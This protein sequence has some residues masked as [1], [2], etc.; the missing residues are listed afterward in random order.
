M[1]LYLAS[2]TANGITTSPRTWTST[3]TGSV[4]GTLA[5]FRALRVTSSPRSPL[6]RV[7]ARTSRPIRYSKE[8]AEPSNF[9]CERKRVAPEVVMFTKWFN[10]S[11][12]VALS[13]LRMGNKWSTLTLPGATSAPTRLN[14]GWCESSCLSSS[15]SRSN[16]A[17]LISG[18]ARL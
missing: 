5:I 17:S 8:R 4:W 6:P 14:C 9:G 13:R 15:Q 10:S 12:V 16:S 2:N 1:S 7:A 3:A 11:A 18:C